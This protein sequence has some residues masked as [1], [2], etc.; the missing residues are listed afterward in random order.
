MDGFNKIHTRNIFEKISQYPGY[1]KEWKVRAES[2]K[3]QLYPEIAA[4]YLH[5][6]LLRVSGSES[7]EI[8]NPW[9]LT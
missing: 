2:F 6:G 4:K 7:K 1:L 5:G 8:N 3:D 9:Y